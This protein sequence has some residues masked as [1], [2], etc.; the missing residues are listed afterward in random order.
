M[1]SETLSRDVIVDSIREELQAFPG[2]TVS[3][4]HSRLTVKRSG[5]RRV[6]DELIESGQVREESDLVGGRGIRRLYW[7]DA[8]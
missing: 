5:W 3:M 1:P 2:V 8:E 6:L 4:L 7:N